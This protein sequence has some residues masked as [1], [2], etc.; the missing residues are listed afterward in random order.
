MDGSV[1]PGRIEEVAGSV[2]RSRR[3]RERDAQYLGLRETRDGVLP[4]LQIDDLSGIPFLDDVVGVERYQLRARVRARHGDI[5]AATCPEMTDYEAYNERLG[6]GS[7]TFVHAPN[8]ESPIEVARACSASKPLAELATIAHSA[9]GMTVHPYMGIAPVWELAE[10][11]SN[12]GDVDVRVLGPAPAMTTLANDKVD[13][14]RVVQGLF[15]DRYQVETRLGR[16]ADELV[17]ALGDLAGRHERVA[18][19]MARCASAMGNRRFDSTELS[20]M[21]APARRA[22]VD[23]FL[24][25]KQW[26]GE[27]EVL[28]VAWE[29]TDCSPSSQLWI[30]P[31]E[32]GPPRVDG[33]Y[34]QLLV[35]PERM[36]LGSV[37]SRL[38]AARDTEISTVSVAIASVF[39]QLGYLG[40][41]S[42]DF[43]I[44]NGKLRVVECNGRWGG[45]STPMHLLDR[46]FNGIRPACRARDFVAPHLIGSPFARLAAG[47]GDHL[48]DPSK[49]TG[50]YVLYNVGCLP[51]YGKFDVIAFAESVD[52]ASALLEGEFSELVARA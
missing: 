43:I 18:L 25:A 51:G 8:P 16:T 50:Q 44:Y 9:G 49:G 46:L 48:F 13:L 20:A 47:L 28:V 27:E 38:G 2:E 23:D 17:V 31:I 37:P 29:D 39:Q 22:L 36:F 30:P 6:L 19:K 4:Q 32:D 15:G 41:C 40:R 34:E 12:A 21:D 42:F 11:I 3:V 52:A 35:G 14:W 33:V 24:A 1:D 7:V 10:A 26:D 5:F 45:T